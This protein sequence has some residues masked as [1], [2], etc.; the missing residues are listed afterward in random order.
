[1]RA[2]HSYLHE[3]PSVNLD[4]NFADRAIK[5]RFRLGADHFDYRCRQVD[6]N[7][8]SFVS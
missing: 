8:R 2:A 5:A 7:I 6:A 3:D 1:M 4:G